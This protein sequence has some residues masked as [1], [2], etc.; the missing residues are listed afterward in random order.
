M[1]HLIKQLLI[2]AIQA[3]LE[4][5]DL[6]LECRATIR[7][8]ISDLHYMQDVYPDRIWAAE[9]ERIATELLEIHRRDCPCYCSRCL[10]PDMD[11]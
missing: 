8:C 5:D 7:E 9:K 3:D 1:P 4:I 6:P 10:A 2:G 11:T